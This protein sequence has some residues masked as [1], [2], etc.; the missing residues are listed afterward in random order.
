MYKLTV[1]ETCDILLS[2]AN[3]KKVKEECL[4]QSFQTALRVV[5]PLFLT[6]ALGYLLRRLKWV[7]DKTL[8]ELNKLVFNVFLPLLLF[9]NVT[10][11]NFKANGAGFGPLF[12]FAGLGILAVFVVAAMIVPLLETDRA[13]RASLVQG[14]FRSNFVLFGIPITRAIMGEEAVVVPSLLAAITIPLFNILAVGI[15]EYYR[16]GRMDVARLLKGIAKNPLILGTLAGLLFVGLGWQ[17]PSAVEP[18]IADLSQVATPLALLVLGGS[19]TFRS[20]GKS[21]KP[22]TVGLIGRLI[23]V[24]LLALSCAV[25]LGFRGVELVA[26]MALFASPSAV[27]SF[28]MAKQMEADYELAGQLVVLSSAFSVIT[29]F[30]C[31]YILSAAQLLA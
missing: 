8:D 4:L 15:L 7:S 21:I 11:A 22:L 14:I 13:R 30:I 2:N 17:L 19:F 6:M 18:V 27:S 23:V 12:L 10:K 1:V 29:I 28:T 31:T 5:T 9:Y 26:L 3:R 16:G 24:P 20:V 25:A